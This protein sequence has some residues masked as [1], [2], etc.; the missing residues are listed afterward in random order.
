[1]PSDA[2]S[3][4]GRGSRCALRRRAAFLCLWALL[5]VADAQQEQER[6]RDLMSKYPLIDGT[7]YAVR[8][9]VIRWTQGVGVPSAAAPAFLC[10]WALLASA[11]RPQ[12]ER[13]RAGR[14]HDAVRLTLEQVDLIRRMCTEYQEL[15]LVTS[16]DEL[17]SAEIEGRIAC[18]LSIEGGHSIDSS[19]P[20]LRMFY[21]LGVR[22]M[23]LTHNCNTPW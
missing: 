23:A 10:L 16:A 7:L 11:E 8:R 1:M 14:P 15:E 12:Q 17:R 18:V 4:G 5:A 22:S 13:D 9:R 3:S 19:L 2:A 20:A 6:A 21:Q